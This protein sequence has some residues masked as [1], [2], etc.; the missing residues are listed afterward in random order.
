MLITDNAEDFIGEQKQVNTPSLLRNG[1]QRK[2]RRKQRGSSIHNGD[3]VN[4]DV[5]SSVNVL[6]LRVSLSASRLDAIPHLCSERLFQLSSHEFEKIQ[7]ALGLIQQSL[8]SEKTTAKVSSAPPVPANNSSNKPKLRKIT[9]VNTSQ[10]PAIPVNLFAD[11]PLHALDEGKAAEKTAATALTILGPLESPL[12]PLPT[13]GTSFFL[14]VCV[15]ALTCVLT[16]VLYIYIIVCKIMMT[17]RWVCLKNP[18]MLKKS[19]V[20]VL[21]AFIFSFYFIIFITL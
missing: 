4:A 9:P 12:L 7:D 19:T 21:L 18:V 2:L 20:S 1:S 5:V 8:S 6:V 10:A 17:W 3:T 14:Q 15:T 16:F 13:P 11:S